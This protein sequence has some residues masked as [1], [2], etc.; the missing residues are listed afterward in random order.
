MNLYPVISEITELDMQRFRQHKMLKLCALMATEMDIKEPLST[1]D[2][3][4]TF[5][6]EWLCLCI[7]FGVKDGSNLEF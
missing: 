6:V 7:M 3:T 5:V 1:S 2:N 4:E